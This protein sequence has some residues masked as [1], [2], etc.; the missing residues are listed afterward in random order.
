MKNVAGR[1]FSLDINGLRELSATDRFGN[2]RAGQITELIFP[3]LKTK[4]EAHIAPVASMV[5]KGK[6]CYRLFYADGSG[7]T[8]YVG[9]KNAEVIPFLF[10]F[11]ASCC[12]SEKDEDGN[13]DTEVCLV[14][15]EDGWVYE[16]EKGGS[17]DGEA[18]QFYAMLPFNHMGSPA[19]NKVFS[20]F[21]LELA[22]PAAVILSV[23]AIFDYGDPSTAPSGSNDLPIQGGGGL[24]D[25]ALFD[26]VV[27]DAPVVSSVQDDLE[28]IGSNCS[29]RI[30]GESTYDEPHTLTGCWVWAKPRGALKREV[31]AS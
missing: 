4:H 29:L 10:P 28:G 6:D 18:M 24:Y 14:G 21:R 1:I 23:I 30:S 31:R 16:M 17:F 12:D 26:T 13:D 5:V 11:V 27:F 20:G 3:L 9:K 7:F 15:T 19:Q 22:T 2:F 8:V 25:E